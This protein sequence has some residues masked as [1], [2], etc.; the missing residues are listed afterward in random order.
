M[1]SIFNQCL[2]AGVVPRCWKTSKLVLLPKPK[3]DPNSPSAYRPICLL[4]ETGKLFERILMSRLSDHLRNVGPDIHR[5][6]FGFRVGRSTIDAIDRV[7]SLA[8]GAIRQGGITLAVSVDIVNAF[9]ALPWNTIRDGL[10][11]HCAPRYIQKTIASYLAGRTIEF[12]ANGTT[13]RRAIDRGVPQGSIL[14]PLLWNLG[15]NAALNTA[16]PDGVHITCYADDTL[17][18]ACGRDWT[19]T[20]RVMEAGLAALTA[21]VAN[22]GLEV[23]AQKTEATW[24]HGLPRTR[25][26]PASWVAVGADRIPVG[27][28]IKYLGLVLDGRFNFEAHFAHL[29]PKLEKVA[30]SLSR[31]LP[32]IGGPKEKIRRLYASVLGSMA[33]YGAPIWAKDK[34]LTRRNAKA[35]RSAQKRMAIRT[36]RAYRTVSGEAALTLAGMVPFDQLAKGYAEIYWGTRDNAGQVSDEARGRAEQLKQQA[37]RCA[38]LNW[39]RE[40]VQ[41]GAGNRRVV[42]A[43]LPNWEQWT[44]SGP[45]TLTYRTTQILTGHG[46]FG[47]YL[48]RIGAESTAVC[49]HCGGDPDSAQHTLEECPAFSAQRAALTAVIGPVL[50]PAALI[51][52]LLSGGRKMNAV[53]S[54]CEEVISFKEAAE[55]QRERAAPGR[56]SRTRRR[57]PPGP[58]SEET[59]G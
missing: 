15:Y 33:L 37:L 23:A 49:H 45:A 10:A 3:K 44:E 32:N 39:K 1:L 41:A 19:R 13:S 36:I 9:N 34:P 52:A 56:S 46:C 20:I 17:L 25:R 42:G 12:G 27:E 22:L 55:R 53:T 59:L 35:L 5:Y 7:K 31:I 43:I 29:A 11:R 51:A 24:F 57:L 48:K 40:L 26:P 18:V 28:S 16:L 38:S 21:R 58:R 4:N 47:D 50:S 54:F 30:L 2:R 8:Q 6:Q 14:G